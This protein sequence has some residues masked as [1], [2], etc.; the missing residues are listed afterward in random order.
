MFRKVFCEVGVC[1]RGKSD[2]GAVIGVESTKEGLKSGIM[3][4]F[5]SSNGMDEVPSTVQVQH[6][7]VVLTAKL[8]TGIFAAATLKAYT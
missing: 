4:C 7:F 3:G 5:C 6:C 8:V 2:C 1:E